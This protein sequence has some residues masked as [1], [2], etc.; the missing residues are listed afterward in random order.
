MSYH[1][2]ERNL[3]SPKFYSTVDVGRMGY[4]PEITEYYTVSGALIRVEEI[5]D[6]VTYTRTISGSNFGSQWPVYDHSIT[7][8][9]WDE[10]TI[11]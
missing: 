5:F 3:R 1:T 2:Y 4:N 6:G 7:Y 11:S 9:A 8:S 10:T